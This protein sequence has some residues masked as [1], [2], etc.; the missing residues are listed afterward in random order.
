MKLLRQLLGVLGARLQAVADAHPGKRICLMFEDEARIG[1]QGRV[2]H[3][4]Y[5]KGRRPPGRVDQRYTFAYVFAAVEPGTDNA[6]ALVMPEVST[7]A[8]Q[9]YLDKLSATVE[10]MLLVLDQAR[11]HGANDLEV[12]AKNHPSAAAASLARAQSGRAPVAVPEGALLLAPPA[13]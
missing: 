5:T 2:C 7:R 8:M 1:Q 6:L 4:W 3:R 13:R 10:H 11:W 12:S 9:S